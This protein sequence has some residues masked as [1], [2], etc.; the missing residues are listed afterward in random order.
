MISDFH[1]DVIS[2]FDWYSALGRT[3]VFISLTVFEELYTK[4][5]LWDFLSL[6]VLWD[7]PVV[8]IEIGNTCDIFTSH[9]SIPF[10]WNCIPI[11]LTTVC[12]RSILTVLIKSCSRSVWSERPWNHWNPPVMMRR[13][14]RTP[15]R[16]VWRRTTG[17]CRYPNFTPLPPSPPAASSVV[18]RHSKSGNLNPNLTPA[19]PRSGRFCCFLSVLKPL[20]MYIRGTS[21]P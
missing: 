10:T 2:K 6:L 20:R 15:N 17:R 9:I 4:L 1:T 18:V 19:T 7:G 14:R 12:Q 3:Q 16:C 5:D 13:P 21:F 8:D 11:R